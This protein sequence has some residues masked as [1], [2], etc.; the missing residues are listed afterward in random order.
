MHQ[1]FTFL[2]YVLVIVC[3]GWN[4]IFE[5]LLNLVCAPILS[6]ALKLIIPAKE[7]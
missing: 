5:F 1:R 3:A 6:R 2:F 4:F 7:K